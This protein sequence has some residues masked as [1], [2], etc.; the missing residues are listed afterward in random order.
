MRWDAMRWSALINDLT[1][2]LVFS[3]DGKWSCGLRRSGQMPAVEEECKRRSWPSAV[4][5][6]E[7][8]EVWAPHD[9]GST[10]EGEDM[11]ENSWWSTSISIRRSNLK[12]NDKVCNRAHVFMRWSEWEMWGL[13]GNS[14]F[15]TTPI[16]PASQLNDA[17]FSSP[18][19]CRIVVMLLLCCHQQSPA[20]IMLSPAVVTWSPLPIYYHCCLLY[21]C[22]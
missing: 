19:F 22:R 17:K 20:V 14:T 21:C 6:Q 10:D 5:E 15:Y 11:V 3:L 2:R 9:Y 16:V 7:E 18:F 1:T 4:E 12:L 8:E 13:P